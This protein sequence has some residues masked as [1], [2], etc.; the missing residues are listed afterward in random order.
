MGLQRRKPLARKKGLTR[1]S[2]LPAGKPP[3]K[4]KGG[5]VAQ[6]EA[7]L[8]NL[9]AQ[10][11][12]WRDGWKC[13]V[14]GKRLYGDEAHAHHVENKARGKVLRWDLLNLVTLCVKHHAWAHEHPAD[15]ETWF[16]GRFPDRWDHIQEHGKAIRKFTEDELLEMERI[17]QDELLRLG[18]DAWKI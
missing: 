11:V 12:K 18:G 6:I 15:F 10:V 17:N 5:L 8:T 3:R 13:Q 9:V 16:A 2:P 14:C 7:Q 4:R 1:K